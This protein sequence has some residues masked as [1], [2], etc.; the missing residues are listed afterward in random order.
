MEADI[1]F[2]SDIVKKLAEELNVPVKEVQE[3]I[4][5]HIAYTKELVNKPEVTS[6]KVGKNIGKLVSSKALLRREIERNKTSPVEKYKNHVELT[7]KPRLKLVEDFIESLPEKDKKSK[8]DKRPF[9][10]MLKKIVNKVLGKRV[11]NV[12]E[13]PHRLWT[14]LSDYQNEKNIQ[15]TKV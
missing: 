4:D 11:T 3:I 1:S 5:L 14:V 15:N 10:F 13:K 9:I 2:G 8:Y 12:Y 7:I 6:I